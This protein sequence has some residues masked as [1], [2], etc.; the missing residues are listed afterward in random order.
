MA[1]GPQ[2]TSSNRSH[3]PIVLVA[4]DDP[5]ERLLIEDVLQ[6]GRTF[7]DVRFVVDGEELLGVLHRDALQPDLIMLEVNLLGMNGHDVLKEIKANGRLR[8]IPVI[9]FTDSQRKEDLQTA[10]DHGASAYI[11]KPSSPGTFAA[12]LKM[13]AGMWLKAKDGNPVSG[14]G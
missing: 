7:L 10:Y 14:P 2:D 3:R 9:F 6:S 4:E 11:V 8:T 1:Y 5:S 13:A 12:T